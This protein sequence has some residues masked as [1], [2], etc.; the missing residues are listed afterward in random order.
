VCVCVCVCV[1]VQHNSAIINHHGAS[2]GGGGPSSPT[3]STTSPQAQ[4]QTLLAN[5]QARLRA[6]E[7]EHEELL[8]AIE[9]AQQAS[10]EGVTV[11]TRGLP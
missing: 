7:Q 11:I 6:N 9:A 1:C 5:L 2:D 4:A 8:Q 3:S 10:H